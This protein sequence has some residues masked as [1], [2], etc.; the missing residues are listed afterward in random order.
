[1]DWFV[2]QGNSRA[3]EGRAEGKGFLP[4][5]FTVGKQVYLIAF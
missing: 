2:Q 3:G 4:P 5:C 1:M